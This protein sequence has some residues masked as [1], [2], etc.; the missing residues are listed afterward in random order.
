VP[1]PGEKAVATLDSL[2]KWPEV[3]ARV[4]NI[5]LVRK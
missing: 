1:T 4:I 3:T 2:K 5:E